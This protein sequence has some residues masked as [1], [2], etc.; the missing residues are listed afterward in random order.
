MDQKLLEFEENFSVLDRYGTNVTKEEYVTNP[1]IGRDKQIKELILILLTPEKS[2]ILIGKP[3]IGKTAIVEGLAYRIQHDEVPDALKG[4]TIINIKTASLLGTMPSGE[5]KVQ[6]MIDELKTKE[7][8][9]LFVDEI[10]MLIG[11][12]D[13]SSLDFA[14]IFK[15]GLGR[16]SIKVIGATTTEEYE[17]YILRDKAFTRRFQKVDV[18]E[19]NH[20]E[21]VEIMMGTLPKFEKQTGKK[22]KYS[23]FIQ[24]RIMT[25]LVDIT[26]E[27]KRV[28]ALGSRYPDVSLT[29]LKQAFSY[30]VYDNRE[31]MDIFD[32][33]KAIEDTKNIYPDVKKKEL[34]R[35][36]KEFEDIILEEK[37]EK[38]IEPWRL[39]KNQNASPQVEEIED[40]PEVLVETYDQMIEE[41]KKAQEVIGTTKKKDKEANYQ[42][43]KFKNDAKDL[44]D[45]LLTGG[46]S[47]LADD[48]YG[49][50]VPRQNVKIHKELKKSGIDDV[51][52]S[53]SIGS[54]LDSN[55][56]QIEIQTYKTN[57]KVNNQLLSDEAKNI[58]IKDKPVKKKKVDLYGEDE[59]IKQ[60]IPKKAEKQVPN[61]FSIN[62]EVAPKKVE[63][64][65]SKYLNRPDLTG[66]VPKKTKEEPMPVEEVKEELQEQKVIEEPKEVIKEE[67]KE[68]VPE[69]VEEIKP[70]EE[71]VIRHND[72]D[73]KLLEEISKYLNDTDYT[74]PIEKDKKEEK[75]ETKENKGDE[76]MYGQNYGGNIDFL[77]GNGNP[78][79]P[80]PNNGNDMYNPGYGM[81]G[82]GPANQDF[83]MGNGNMGSNMPPY[84]GNGM[85]MP[86]Q[87]GMMNQGYGMQAPPPQNPANQFIPGGVAEPPKPEN[88][89]E[90]LFGVPMYDETKEQEMTGGNSNPMNQGYGMQAPPPQQG[91][92]DPFNK[93][94]DSFFGAPMY[95][96][97]ANEDV[98]SKDNDIF[99]Q[100]LLPENNMRIQGG[101]IV[102]DFS[103]I[104]VAPGEKMIIG[105]VSSPMGNPGFGAPPQNSFGQAPGM[106]PQNNFGPPPQGGFGMD[107]GFGAPPQNNFGM[108][109][110][111]GP[112][113][114]NSFGPD[115]GMMPQNNFGPPPQGGF[116]MD[117]G[118][119]AP[120]QNNFGMDPGFGPPPQ[121]SFGPDPGMMPQ[122]NF[123]PPPQGGFGMDTGFGV[124]PQNSFGMDPGF[125]PPP[126]N[127][128]YGMQGG[129]MPPQNQMYGMNGGMNQMMPPGAYTSYQTARGP[130]FNELKVENN[131]LKKPAEIE[132]EKEEEEE[133]E[134]KAKEALEKAKKEEEDFVNY[135]DLKNGKVDD[136]SKY[137]SQKE[138]EDEKPVPRV[139][140][141]LETGADDE[142]D[143][144]D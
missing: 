70:K 80:P 126:M 57:D 7:K 102:D 84:G 133:E 140:L 45:M 34:P 55:E 137:V 64:D 144:L 87:G 120:P 132:K 125:G 107:T 135:S 83:L 37:G 67:I 16:G 23:P 139:D 73:D 123:G 35:F 42:R 96:G 39:D 91:M 128:G 20:D 29:L 77:M 138:D 62:K 124:P 11:A 28:Y 66:D 43:K 24:K 97:N 112:P 31:L 19:P 2:A 106:M 56:E 63:I 54:I 52:L 86:G 143:Y 14:N 40:N 116:G 41:Q 36:D 115:P 22:M 8:V 92:N 101:K 4:Y 27:Y 53:G 76:S 109:P 90:T 134:R 68:E 6:K 136:I 46:I 118:F 103:D 142:D 117:T 122:N 10:H 13:T 5:S 50:S 47:V 69:K 72:S 104:N 114:Q 60:N 12:T 51:L 79:G 105:D 131:L 98:Y 89:R 30:A 32:V 110:G 17:R 59:E 85:G 99:G 74:I 71:P 61:N 33:R 119:G 108:D 88:N 3:G 15:E 38:E 141:N 111:F 21:T 130:V 1:A 44:D 129:M 81:P 18:P 26:S 58:I 127:Q 95:Q 25:F 65:I 48:K 75:N 113:P 9:I 82:Q 49:V 94:N 121:N 93:P 100:L 78:A